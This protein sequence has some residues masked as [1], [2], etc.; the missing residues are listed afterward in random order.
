MSASLETTPPPPARRRVTRPALDAEGVRVVL[1]TLLFRGA[2][3]PA[4]HDDA[5]C[6]SRPRALF[7]P[8]TDGARPRA[9]TV[10]AAKD[11]CRR[12]PVRAVCLEDVMTYE[13]PAHRHGVVGG[14]SAAERHHRHGLHAAPLGASS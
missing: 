7:F 13:S 10:R 1:R 4:W 9:A 5:A 12:C 8:D 3:V 11:V 14:L 2:S 6:A